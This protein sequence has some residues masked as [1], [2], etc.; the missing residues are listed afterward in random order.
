[1][2][3]QGNK[4]EDVVAQG[5]AEDEEDVMTQGD[6]DEEYKATRMWQR[7][8]ARTRTWCRGRGCGGEDNKKDKDMEGRGR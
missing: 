7:E 1:M 5:V 4:E 2:V 8:E 3:A 6:G